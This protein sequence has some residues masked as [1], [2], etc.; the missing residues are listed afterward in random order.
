MSELNPDF[1][2]D[3]FDD[4]GDQKAVIAWLDDASVDFNEKV[5]RAGIVERKELERSGKPRDEVT[6]AISRARGEGAPAETHDDSRSES[7][8]P[9]TQ[10]TRSTPR[11]QPG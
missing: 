1:R 11:K 3:D 2:D 4:F 10:E 5:R 7:K 9:R 6:A 8:G